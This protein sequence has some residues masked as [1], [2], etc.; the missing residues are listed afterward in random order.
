MPYLIRMS[1]AAFADIPNRVVPR[2]VRLKDPDLTTDK[3]KVWILDGYCEKLL[4]KNAKLEEL[5]RQFPGKFDD[6]DC[7][8]CFTQG[9]RILHVL[10]VFD[11]QVKNG[12]LTRFF[13]N[14]PDLIFEVPDALE[15]L[16]QTALRHAYDNA[17]EGLVGNKDEWIEL[18]KKFSNDPGDAWQPFEKSYDLLDLAWFD[19]AYFKTYGQSLVAGLVNYVKCHKEEFIESRVVEAPSAKH[20]I[21]PWIA[22]AWGASI[23]GWWRRRSFGEN[24]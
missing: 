15:P 17:M 20:C 3:A 18:R 21:L 8:D 1:D 14:Y 23:C 4:Y 6:P 2:T 16:G 11:G 19:D 22:P 9:Q 12:G 7:R 5:F 10:S 13:W 24:I